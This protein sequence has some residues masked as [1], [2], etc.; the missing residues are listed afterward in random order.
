MWTRTGEAGGDQHVAAEH[1][2]GHVDRIAIDSDVDVVGEHSAV[3]LHREAA[4]N[5]APFVALREDNQVG[6]VAAIDHCLHR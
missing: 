3:E 1:R 5:V 6:G 4:D 2:R